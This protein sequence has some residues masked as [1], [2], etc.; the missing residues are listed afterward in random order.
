M[1]SK[2]TITSLENNIPS[3]NEKAVLPPPLDNKSISG[4]RKL[5][6]EKIRVVAMILTIA[7]HCSQLIPR[8]TTT[9]QY[10]FDAL[11]S[12]F[13]ICNGLFFM[14][15][16][17]FSLSVKIETFHDYYRY[18]TKKLITLIIPIL[19][20]MFLRSLYDNGT[21]LI[22]PYF[23]KSYIK[24]VFSNYASN[25]YWFL[26]GLVGMVL[27]APFLN[28][29]VERLTKPEISLFLSM[30]L[31]YNSILT[32]GPYFNLSFSWSFIFSGWVFYFLLGY[33]LEKII[34]TPKKEKIIFLLG[35][36]SFFISF[37]QK[38]FELTNHIHDYAPTYTFMVCAMFFLLKKELHM[39]NNAF[40][41]FLNTLI[42]KCGKY[43]FAIYMVHNPVRKF[44][45]DTMHFPVDGNYLLSLFMLI[46][47]TVI[48]S[49]LLAFI[50]ENTFVRA[51]KW[52]VGK[53]MKYQK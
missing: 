36:L 42:M 5:V 1:P 23:W 15:S 13:Y 8:H 20:Y 31:L 22:P 29:M 37:I 41:A 47:C 14:L 18:Y 16:G 2:E 51:L 26:Y 52:C 32:Y 50:C 30:G 45:V 33:F 44:L 4:S 11:S 53:V 6:Y 24:N 49:F 43:S 39:K 7:V 28:K 3:I 19:F 34:D 21:E 38:Q 9:E 25:E 17:K 40:H 27:L 35:M 12:L 48:V 46:V 10:M